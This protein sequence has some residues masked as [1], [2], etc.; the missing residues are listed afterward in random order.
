MNKVTVIKSE[1]YTTVSNLPL[2]NKNLSWKAKGVL[3]YLMT[4]PSSWEIRLSDLENRSTDGRDS[5]NGAIKELMEARYISRVP[6]EE[7][8]KFMGYDYTVSDEPNQPASEKPQRFI[9]NGSPATENPTLVSTHSVNTQKEE[10]PQT[11]K[12]ATPS[13]FDLPPQEPTDPSKPTPEN[14]IAYLNKTAGKNFKAV[15]GNAT[16]VRARI[17]EG[18]TL[19]DFQS[20]IDRRTA[21]WG[22]DSKMR[23]YLRP[24]TLFSAKHFESYL[25][26]DT[27]SEDQELA[28]RIRQLAGTQ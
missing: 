27:K 1:N 13:L 4:L 10:F 9:R 17:K 28:E 23:E 18:Y 24:E 6:V 25:N 12:G 3:M 26:D 22:Q 8:G 7:K 15:N 2:Q 14:V 11:P 21:K 5:T 19:A 16:L 20:V